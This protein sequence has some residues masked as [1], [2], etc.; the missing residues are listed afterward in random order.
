MKN[1]KLLHVCMLVLIVAGAG[2]FA[3][4]QLAVRNNIPVIINTDTLKNA[5]GG[6]VNDPVWGQIEL[7]GDGLPDLVMFDSWDNSFLP[8][9]NQGSSKPVYQF[10]PEHYQAFKNCKCEYWA[11]FADYDH[12]GDLDLFC[13]NNSNVSLYSNDPVDGRAVFNVVEASLEAEYF[14]PPNLNLFSSKVFLPDVKDIDGDGDLDFFTWP[15]FLRNSPELYL[16]VGVDSFNNPDTMALKF[17]T[18]CW[19]HFSENAGDGSIAIHDTINCPLGNFSPKD[20]GCLD[21]TGKALDPGEPNTGREKHIGGT[22]LLIDMDGDEKFDLLLGDIGVPTITYLHNCGTEDYAYIDTAYIDFPA[23]DQPI[24][25]FSNPGLTY[26]DFNNDGISDLLIGTYEGGDE[27]S[28]NKN[29]VMWYE[30]IGAETAPVFQYRQRGQLTNQMEDL[31]R[32][33][34]PCL[35]DV[36][37]D[38]LL[39]MIVGTAGVYDR[40]DSSFSYSLQLYENVGSTDRAIFKLIDTDFLNTAANPFLFPSPTAGDVDKDGDLDIL[41]GQQN[42]EI[43]FYENT[44]G[45]GQPATFTLQARAYKGLDAGVNASPLLYDFDGDQDMDLLVGNSL[46]EIVYYRNVSQTNAPD[47]FLVTTRWGYFG[48]QDRFGRQ[49]NGENAVPIIMNVDSDPEPELVVGSQG[50]NVQIYEGVNNALL[51]TL[52]Y[53]GDLLSGFDFGN[54]SAPV[55]AVLDSTGDMSF[56]VGVGRGG[57]MLANTLPYDEIEID[58]VNSVEE[59]GVLPA[60]EVSVFPN[61]TDGAVTISRTGKPGSLQARVLDATG[62]TVMNLGALQMGNRRISL[63][64]VAPGVY[65]LQVQNEITTKTYRV[66]RK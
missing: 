36:N 4:G 65:F 7:N 35:M 20:N 37:A 21:K 23:Y 22:N 18:D 43:A 29:P 42:G 34:K 28:E 30:N 56:I 47:Y 32:Y 19:G 9:I 44:A 61:P 31:G 38:G 55:A 16:N 59:D 3:K 53:S 2:N 17:I 1:P 24:E 45:M 62:R 66:V 40:T 64:D 41:I 60:W 13:S 25:L 12:D 63:A 52:R 51:D 54:F 50:G 8:F 10:S 39:D 15:A 27:F 5:W 14:R 6:G 11:R 49:N 46:G 48:I 57:L 26:M 33:A 58:R